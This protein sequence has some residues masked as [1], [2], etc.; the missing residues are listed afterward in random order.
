[1]RVSPVV[2]RAGSKSYA[3][4]L[5]H[6]ASRAPVIRTEA[7]SLT[8]AP[9]QRVELGGSQGTGSGSSWVQ[10]ATTFGTYFGGASGRAVQHGMPNGSAFNA[11]RTASAIVI[12]AVTFNNALITLN[13]RSRNGYTSVSDAPSAQWRMTELSYW[14]FELDKPMTMNP[15]QN[16]GPIDYASP[17]W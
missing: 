2:G 15:D 7:Q 9:L 12:C 3:S 11:Q 6:I 10:S 4:W 13:G 5:E 17:G 16:T 1:M 8:T 14:D